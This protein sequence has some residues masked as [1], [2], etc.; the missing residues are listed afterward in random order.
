MEAVGRMLCYYGFDTAWDRQFDEIR[1]IPPFKPE[2]INIPYMYLSSEHPKNIDSVYLFPKYVYSNEKYFLQFNGGKHENFS[3]IFTV[4][5]SVAPELGNID[6]SRH[7]MV[8]G[9]TRTFFSQ[10]LKK[11]GSVKTVDYI[12]KL[13]AENPKFFSIRYPQK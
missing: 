12:S 4:G 10:Y 13:N 6:S 11:S 1:K 8:C 3:S 9:L 7:E 2:A 5:K